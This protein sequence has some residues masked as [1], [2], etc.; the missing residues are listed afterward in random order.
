MSSP[1][2]KL[3]SP[4]EVAITLLA[5]GINQQYDKLKD[6]SSI[7]RQN[8]DELEPQLIVALPRLSALY[9]CE[10]SVGCV[11]RTIFPCLY[12]GAWDAPYAPMPLS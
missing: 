10:A 4:P 7:V 5:Q 2:D 11:L 1:Y 3:V 6:N 12:I 9:M 8:E